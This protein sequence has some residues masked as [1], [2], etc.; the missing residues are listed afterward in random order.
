VSFF[1]IPDA[2]RLDNPKADAL[3]RVQQHGD[4]ALQESNKRWLVL[5]PK[6]RDSG[7]GFWRYAWSFAKSKSKVINTRASVQQR[8]E[9]AESLA[10]EESFSLQT[11]SASNPAPRRIDA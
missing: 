4:E 11:V 7:M 2:V 9:S 10:P 8:S 1:A 3:A 5:G 6:D